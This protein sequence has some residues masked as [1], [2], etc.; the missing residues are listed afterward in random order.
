MKRV[1]RIVTLWLVLIVPPFQ[2]AT[3]ALVAALCEPSSGDFSIVLASADR[4]HTDCG[5]GGPASGERLRAHGSCDKCSCYLAAAPVLPVS[6]STVGAITADA[7]RPSPNARSPKISP[8][9][10]FHPP[11]A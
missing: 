10:P 11:S 9:R 7:P 5:K 8:E 1:V 6:V 4:D 2:S 3:A